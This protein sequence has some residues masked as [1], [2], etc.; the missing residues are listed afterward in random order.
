MN[1]DLIGKKFKLT[2]SEPWE[3]CTAIRSA[4][5]CVEVVDVGEEALLLQITKPFTFEG[6]TWHL[7]SAANRHESR[8]SISEL[9]M[10]GSSV[11][12]NA[13]S[14]EKN[15]VELDA[16]TFGW[17]NYRGKRAMVIGLLSHPQYPLSLPTREHA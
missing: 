12:V 7:L 11:A 2:I 14:V 13:I 5:L 1:R 16:K 3:C 17:R 8:G 4:S 6:D 15:D 10:S 9:L